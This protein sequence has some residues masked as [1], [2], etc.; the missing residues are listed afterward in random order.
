MSRQKF[1]CADVLNTEEGLLSCIHM[2]STGCVMCCSGAIWPGEKTVFVSG[3]FG[4]QCSVAPARGQ[5]FKE[6]VGWV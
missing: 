3:C 1:E 5:Q 4:A 2:S 6:R